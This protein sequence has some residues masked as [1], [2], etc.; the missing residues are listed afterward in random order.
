M[1]FA[2]LTPEEN[3]LIESALQDAR[4]YLADRRLPLPR[5][6][7]L[8]VALV[9]TDALLRQALRR[10]IELQAARELVEVVAMIRAATD[11]H[12][13]AGRARH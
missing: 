11:E 3:T 1:T 10:L 12:P 2:P 6:H 5:A 9:R 13:P 4:A 8:A 7:D